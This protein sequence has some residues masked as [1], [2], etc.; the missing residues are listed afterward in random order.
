MFPSTIAA[1]S[2]APRVL[3]YARPAIKRAGFR[4]PQPARRF[5]STHANADASASPLAAGLAGGIVALS[6]GYAWYHISGV[7]KVVETAKS[8]IETFETAKDKVVTATP[9]PTA[10]LGFVRSTISSYAAFLP[11]G[12]KETL[13]SAFESLDQLSS[14]PHAKEAEKILADTYAEL[15]K[16]FQEGGFD[17]STAEKVQHV[18]EDKSKALRRLM[19]DVGQEILDKNPKLAETLKSTGDSAALQ[20][21]KKFASDVGPEANEIIQ[22]TYKELN[23]LLK[24]GSVTDPT[25]LYKATSIIHE[26][27]QAVKELSSKAAERAWDDAS[28]ALKKEGGVLDKLPSEVKTALEDNMD[29]LR[30]VALSGGSVG[31]VYEIFKMIRKYATSND[32]DASSKLKEY[33][34]Q[35]VGEGKDTAQSMANMSE[36]SWG[37]AVEM[38]EKY[39]KSMPGGEKALSAAPPMK[40]L[41]KLAQQKSPEARKLMEDTLKDLSD[42]LNKRL[43]QA[44]ELAGETK[45]EGKKAA[46]K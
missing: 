33:I 27:T 9:S 38:V 2:A 29:G 1:R 41:Y 28:A 18:V 32:K 15:K 43:E 4:A 7:K 36:E 26:K 16:I 46:K 22:D 37:R 39:V 45:E 23:D 44:K 5:Q 3:I 8:T 10:A 21:L 34:T 42:V 31:G 30:R 17:A 13:D 40:E 35:K 12:T 25:T 24:N 19:G 11:K 14:G 20:E 6:G